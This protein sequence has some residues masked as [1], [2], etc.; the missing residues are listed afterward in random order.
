[1]SAAES[2]A[3]RTLA[4]SPVLMLCAAPAIGIAALVVAAQLATLRSNEP[5]LGTVV[6][7]AAFGVGVVVLCSFDKAVFKVRIAR[8][9]Y[10]EVGMFATTLLCAL[11]IS[12]RT[13][14]LRFFAPTVYGIDG[15]HHAAI[16]RWI[17]DH[18]RIPRGYKADLGTISGY[19]PGAHTLPSVL[20]ITTGLAPI[21]SLWIVSIAAVFL[22]WPLV[23]LIANAAARRRNYGATLVPPIVMMLAWRFTIGLIT[24]DSF[25]AQAVGLYLCVAGVAV[26]ARSFNSNVATRR[27]LPTAGLLGFASLI[28]YPQQSAIVPAAVVAGLLTRRHAAVPARLRFA[29]VTA[30]VALSALFAYGYLRSQGYLVRSAVLGNGEGSVTLPTSNT[31]GGWLTIALVLVGVLVLVCESARRHASS[32]ALLAAGASPAILGL[33]LWA[34]QRG[35]FVHFHVTTYRIAKNVYSAVPFA[36]AAVG[37]AVSWAFERARLPRIRSF[38]IACVIAMSVASRPKSLGSTSSPL[39]DRDAYELT[40]WAAFHLRPTDV[41]LVG[42]SLEPYTLW[43]SAL[44]RPVDKL[45]GPESSSAVTYYLAG[46]DEILVSSNRRSMRW[47]DWPNDKTHETYIVVMGTS[48]VDDYLARPNVE[49]IRR[50]GSAAVL[51]RVRG[52]LPSSA[53]V[54]TPQQGAPGLP[55]PQP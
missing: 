2:N 20:S 27:W 22:Q 17:I 19:P 45:R 32:A 49:L 12:S 30:T 25:F 10:L 7:I 44:G 31:L 54:G 15:A 42:P 33:G 28:V 48:L 43:F 23:A 5:R 14:D 6:L 34:A 39:A 21:T 55:R 47:V 52:E 26:V 4:I 8:P 18:G 29:F 36:A 41:G 46:A 3:T 9:S 1:M 35:Y 16:I 11:L 50:N 38:G 53:G 13:F 40:R 24:W 37:V 51:K